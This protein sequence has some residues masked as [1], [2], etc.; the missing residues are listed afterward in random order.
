MTLDA[1]EKLKKNPR[2]NV[3]DDCFWQIKYQDDHRGLE[4]SEYNA[5]LLTAN[6]S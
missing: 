2:N 4:L 1:V 3:I 5:L 6:K